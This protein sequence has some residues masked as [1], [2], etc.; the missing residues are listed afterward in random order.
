MLS[1]LEADKGLEDCLELLC[2]IKL[3]N[4]QHIDLDYVS[5]YNYTILLRNCIVADLIENERII[6]G[7]S[8]VTFTR[9]TLQFLFLWVRFLCA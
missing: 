7:G 5:L 3:K 8:K 4:Q 1:L 9:Y 6:R 2:S